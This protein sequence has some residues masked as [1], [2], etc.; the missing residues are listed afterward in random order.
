[1]RLS[2]ARPSLYVYVLQQHTKISVNRE[3][4][5]PLEGTA[6]SLFIRFV[7]IPGTPK[8]VTC[9]ATMLKT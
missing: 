8:I 5:A 6:I 7:S 2:K 3:T 9:S 1:M 4:N